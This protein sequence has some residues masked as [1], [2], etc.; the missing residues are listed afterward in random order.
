MEETTYR[1]IFDVLKEC[2]GNPENFN[3]DT[4]LVETELRAY[5]FQRIISDRFGLDVSV[6][7]IKSHCTVSALMDALAVGNV[8][9]ADTTDIV[10]Y[11]KNK[12]VF[13]SLHNNDDCLVSPWISEEKLYTIRNNFNI[14]RGETILLCRDTSF[15]SNADQELVI[16]NEGLYYLPDN[17]NKSE[18]YYIDWG[19]V[20]YVQYQELVLYFYNSAGHNVGSFNIRPQ[21]RSIIPCEVLL[22]IE[23]TFLGFIH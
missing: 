17:N 19:D 13:A 5:K 7:E 11:F 14:D 6:D 3:V 21:F 18:R 20:S 23:V 15:W 2:C 22:Y 1:D 16:T 12:G 9:A 4:K 10:K 8:A